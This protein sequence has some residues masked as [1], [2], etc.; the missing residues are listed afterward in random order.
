MLKIATCQ[1]TSGI[2]LSKN[3]EEAESFIRKAAME[4]CNLVCLPE[5]FA[6]MPRG[7][8]DVLVFA[9]NYG[10]GPIQARISSLAKNLG[11][12]IIAGSIALFSDKKDHV[13]NTC[14]VYDP[15]GAVACRYDKIHLFSYHTEEERY[16]EGSLYTPGHEAKSFIIPLDNGTD[17]KIG[18]AICYDLRFPGL[19]RHLGSPD[20]IVIPSAFTETTGRAHWETLVRARAI[21]NL[22][23]VCAPAQAGSNPDGRSFWGHSMAVDCWGKI[24]GEMGQDD[25]GVFITELDP[26]F[27]AQVR[28]N[29]PALNNRVFYD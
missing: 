2:D 25:N 6:L 12:W 19:F 21:E 4:G 26:R 14:L 9:E 27:I 17:I 1:M 13:T 22:C 5:T 11:L 23:Y 16:D 10:E 3:L 18:L 24:L 7:R 20:L 8:Q 29:L 15:Y 28:N